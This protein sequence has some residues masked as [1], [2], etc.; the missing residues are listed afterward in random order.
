[1]QYLVNFLVLCCL[2]S[3]AM[4]GCPASCECENKTLLCEVCLSLHYQ[5]YDLAT[6][7]CKCLDNFQKFHGGKDICC[8]N[9]CVKCYSRGCATCK[10]HAS[11]LWNNTFKYYQCVCDQNYY[12]EGTDCACR[13]KRELS[14]YYVNTMKGTCNKCPEGCNCS[15]N[16]CYPCNSEANRNVAESF[17]NVKI[18]DCIYPFRE[19][20]GICRCPI[21]CTCT[22]ETIQCSSSSHFYLN[23]NTWLC[24]EPYVLKDGSCQCIDP[25]ILIEV[26]GNLQ[27]LCKSKI[28]NTKY[29]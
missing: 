2:V 1:M 15:A 11:T 6:S 26:F 7:G 29:Y 19:V 16:G 8:P 9:N 3:V 28:D 21:N 22:N 13:A 27:C 10:E 18:C 24:Q 20:E 25:Y 12:L 5:T 4:A 17:G 23:G 14:K